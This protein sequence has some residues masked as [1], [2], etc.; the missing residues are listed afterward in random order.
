MLSKSGYQSNITL[1][2]IKKLYTRDSKIILKE[3]NLQ[4]N[5]SEPFWPQVNYTSH[6]L[7]SQIDF[8]TIT[9]GQYLGC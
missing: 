5:P 9:S 3:E 1:I 7:L 4:P 6:P 2:S 8:T